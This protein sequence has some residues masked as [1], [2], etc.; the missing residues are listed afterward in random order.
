MDDT[1]RLFRVCTDD[2][3]KSDILEALKAYGDRIV[4]LRQRGIF[5][6]FID[7]REE[8]IT[9]GVLT[10]YFDL[11]PRKR[12]AKPK[13]ELTEQTAAANSASA[14][15]RRRASREKAQQLADIRSEAKSAARPTRARAI[16]DAANERGLTTTRGRPWRADTVSRLLRSYDDERQIDDHEDG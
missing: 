6:N 14:K 1:S 2:E 8:L 4:D 9:S 5:S 13:E 7:R 3:A 15:T 11:A 16:A 10:P 12:R